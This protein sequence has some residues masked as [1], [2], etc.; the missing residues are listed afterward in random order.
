MAQ[1]MQG[2]L[3]KDEGLY[4]LPSAHVFKKKKSGGMSVTPALWE[5][6]QVDPDSSLASYGPI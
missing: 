5:L 3:Y 4:F 1:S 2:L 6:R